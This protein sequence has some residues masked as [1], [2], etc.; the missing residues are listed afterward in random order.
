MI[1]EF[2]KYIYK[3]MVEA[4]PPKPDEE[5]ETPSS[6]GEEMPPDGGED[7]SGELD[8]EMPMMPEKLVFPEEIELAKLA[9]RALYFNK[10]SKD[11]HNLKM[12]VDK[13]QIPF[14]KIP[15][16]FEKT[17]NILSV[18]G[19]VEWV[20]DKYEGLASKWTEQPKIKGKSITDKIKY[21]QSL[22]D[23]KVL[24]NGKRVYWTRIILNALIQGSP[25]MNI[26]IGDVNEQNITEVFRLL[27][28]HFG[29]DT[30]GLISPDVEQSLEGP[31]IF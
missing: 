3:L 1:S 10:D 14:E 20:M 11:T 5:D 7:L 12:R 9:I 26:N 2:D 8:Q 16:Y 28:Q 15:D 27:K 19:F 13:Q 6:G 21:F 22:P 4:G 29:R 18:L 25:S 23:D 24:D 31:G 17:K 30:R